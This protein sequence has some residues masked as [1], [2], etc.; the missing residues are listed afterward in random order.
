[1]TALVALI[2]A[3]AGTVRSD[4]V[5]GHYAAFV[6]ALAPTLSLAVNDS[7]TGQ[8]RTALERFAA[9]STA[10]A[11]QIDTY[12]QATSDML[13]W[14]ARLAAAQRVRAEPNRSAETS[15]KGFLSATAPSMIN[16]LSAELMGTA[17]VGQDLIGTSASQCAVSDVANNRTYCVVR[18]DP[19]LQAASALLRAALLCADSAEPLDL[20]AALAL[21]RAGA[22]TWRRLVDR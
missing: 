5:A 12:R 4:E 3:D 15:F 17:N 7:F 19:R 6:Q 16:S 2:D 1:M 9:K 10:L 22:E 11:A 13:R 8:F 18:L 21:A 14:R 20:E